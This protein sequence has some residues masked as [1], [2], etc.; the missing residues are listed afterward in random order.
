MS[1]RGTPACDFER[2]RRVKLARMAKTTLVKADQW[3][4]G[5]SRSTDVSTALEHALAQLKQKK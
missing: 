3:A 1:V 4:R 5:E 2:G